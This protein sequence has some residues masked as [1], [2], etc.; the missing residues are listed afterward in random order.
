MGPSEWGILLLLA[1]VW[2]GSFLFISL[3]LHSFP[4]LT[5]VL[6]RCALASLAL[7]VLLRISATR[8]PRS[9]V[10]WWA[11]LRLG[12]LNIALPFALV[13]WSQLQIDTGLAAILNATTPLWGVIVCHLFTRDEKATRG[14]IIGVL[15]GMAG[16]AAMIGGDAFIGLD[17]H[18]PAQIACVAAALSYAFAGL[19]SR[20][21]ADLGIAP[22]QVAAGQMI[23]A[24]M[25]LL[26]VAL[27]VDAPWRLPVPHAESLIAIAALGL[28]S[29]ALAYI[30]F[31]R[32][33]E[34]AGATNAL[35]VTF[36]VPLSAILLGTLVLGE[37]LAPRH[38]LGM[39]MIALGLAAI[40][41]RLVSLWRAGPKARPG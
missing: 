40:D 3:A 5:L 21:F 14:K 25:L 4:P 39:A 10:A 31:F 41:G 38:I 1:T 17:R 27:L 18:L 20:G 8:L 23:T 2:G 26:P 36:L 24:A 6:L 29:T 11:F 22:I 30:L 19:Y 12:I 32:L 13:A 28:V 9:A 16:V 7:F 33:V 15:L 35:L 34:T 37:S